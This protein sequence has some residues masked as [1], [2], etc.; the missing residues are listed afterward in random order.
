MNVVHYIPKGLNAGG[1]LLS[2]S[3]ASDSIRVHEVGNVLLQHDVLVPLLVVFLMNGC[4]SLEKVY[5]MCVER[6]KA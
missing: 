1:R 6:V 2:T 5:V 4:H 3:I